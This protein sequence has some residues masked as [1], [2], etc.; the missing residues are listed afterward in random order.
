M[1]VTRNSCRCR[2]NRKPRPAEML[3]RMY[4]R[5]IEKVLKSIIHISD[6]EEVELSQ[7]V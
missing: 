1:I 7:L 6:G 5:W 2:R 4:S 3:S